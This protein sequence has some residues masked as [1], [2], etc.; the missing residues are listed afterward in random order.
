MF[1]DCKPKT[2]IEFHWLDHHGKRH[3][4]KTTYYYFKN[5]AI[6]LLEESH[7]AKVYDVY[8]TVNNEITHKLD[9][10]NQVF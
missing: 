8:Y 9:Y 1:K 6:Q 2:P 7:I 10:Y 3:S 5:Y 4:L